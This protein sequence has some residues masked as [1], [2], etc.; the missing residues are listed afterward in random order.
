MTN[1]VKSTLPDNLRELRIDPV[2]GYLH[3]GPDHFPHNSLGMYKEEDYTRKT[4]GSY[5][6]WNRHVTNS[7]GERAHGTMADR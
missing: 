3:I 6:Y 4:R 5:S 2:T 1:R 7:T